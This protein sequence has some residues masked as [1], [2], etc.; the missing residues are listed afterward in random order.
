MKPLNLTQ[1]PRNGFIVHLLVIVLVVLLVLSF[2]GLFSFTGAWNNFKQTSVG[3][4]LA[5]ILEWI[6]NTFLAPIWASLQVLFTALWQ[7]LKSWFQ[8]N[9]ERQLPSGGAAGI[10]LPN[11]LKVSVPPIGH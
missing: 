4:W 3:K 9:V 6:W 1:E 8:T 5:P 11:L 2:L 10:T 7:V